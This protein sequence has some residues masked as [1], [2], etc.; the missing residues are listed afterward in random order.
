MKELVN[1]IICALVDDVKN[2]FVEET[3]KDGVVVIEVK[4]P[5]NQIGKVIGRNGRIATSIRNI[6]KGISAKNDKKYIVKIGEN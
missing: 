1:Y 6:V 4:V 5:A 2:V 3:E